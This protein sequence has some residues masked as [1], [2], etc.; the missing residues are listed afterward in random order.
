M[1]LIWRALFLLGWGRCVCFERWRLLRLRS[2][3]LLFLLA[4]PLV[5]GFLGDC[6]LL[7]V[8]VEL[9]LVFD[10]W[11]ADRTDLVDLTTEIVIGQRGQVLSSQAALVVLRLE[12]LLTD[13]AFAGFVLFYDWIDINVP[14]WSTLNRLL[15]LIDSFHFLANVFV[16]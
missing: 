4:N 10:N 9:R 3:R 1:F 5:G 16:V 2:F 7:V 13:L 15:V 14:V 12:T 6:L 8:D 11:V